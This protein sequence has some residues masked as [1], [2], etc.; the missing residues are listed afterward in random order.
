VSTA[1]VPDYDA[2]ADLYDADMGRNMPFDDVGFYRDYATRAA[3]PVLELGCGNGRVLLALLASGIAAVG[4]D[5]A[6]R[7]LRALRD[8]AQA[9][10]M[11]APVARMDVRS[12]GF[13]DSSFACVLCPYSLVTYMR[14]DDDTSRLLTGIARVL[15]PGGHLA[16]D[17][18]IPR[19]A[20]ASEEFRLD[21]RRPLPEGSLERAK[22]IT[23]LDARHNRI[24]RRYRVV[25]ASGAVLR[26]IH[27][28]EEIQ[29][30]TP[31]ELIHAVC[32][33]G[34]KVERACW[35]YGSGAR[36]AETQF[37]TVLAS[38]R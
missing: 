2:I 37:C 22:R 3:G 28:S 14:D 13:A 7:M 1:G 34:F 24:E 30:F 36:A 4:V 19:Q 8:R 31:E 10:E 5:A 38:R 33:R 15:R 12:L 11:E 17:A 35:D 6:D 29:L 20:A 23:P 26:E 16:L 27:T 9:R 21:Y 18:F 32:A 25:D